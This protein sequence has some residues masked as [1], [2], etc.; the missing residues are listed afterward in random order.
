MDEER[1]LL[2]KMSLEKRRYTSAPETHP[3]YNREWERFYNYKRTHYGPI[4]ASRLHD[5]W[6]D[7]WKKYFFD[8]HDT[9]V[10]Q[11]RNKLM[12]GMKV[13]YSD[14]QKY[15][16]NLKIEA[17]RREEAKRKEMRERERI[18]EMKMQ[19][20]EERRRNEMNR[21]YAS[22]EGTSH[23]PHHKPSSTAVSVLSTLRL[24]TAI[25]SDLGDLG[26]KVD[27]ALMKAVQ[28]GGTSD[29]VLLSEVAFVEILQSCR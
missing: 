6:A 5:E 7:V 27:T 18:E 29:A 16:K 13:Y 4:H 14:L 10:R 1:L 22:G 11:E 21:E 17:M 26:R 23:A 19:E 8:V 15:Q 9:Y 20:F 12:N 24:L 3:D 25:E 28:S 2:E